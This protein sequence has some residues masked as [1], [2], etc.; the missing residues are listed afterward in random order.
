MLK[1]YI[2]GNNL[3]QSKVHSTLM[4]SGTIARD[5]SK[6]RQPEIFSS[7]N[8]SVQAALRILRYILENKTVYASITSCPS[9]VNIVN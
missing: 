9:A 1:V 6:R 3:Q 8:Y 2:L 7:I 5:I 4:Q